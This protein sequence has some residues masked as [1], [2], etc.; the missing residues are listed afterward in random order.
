MKLSAF[1]ALAATLASPALADMTVSIP[2]AAEVGGKPFTCDGTFASLGATA[3]EVQVSDFRLFVSNPALVKA[4]GSLQPIA[5]D[6]DGAWQ[7]GDLALLDFE[8]ATGACANGT[9]GTNTTLRGTVPEGDYTGLAFTVG[10]PF[11][12]NHGD[13]TVSDAPLNV[14]AMFW[15]WQAGYKFVRIDMVPTAMAAMPMAEGEMEKAVDAGHG[16]GD[17]KGWF[18]HLGSTMCEA[19][20]KTEPPTACANGNRIEV[21]LAGFDPGANTVVIDPAPVVAG[22]DLMVNAPDTSPGCMS[23]PGDGDC[24]TVMP[25]LGL[26]FMDQPAGA[27]ALVTMR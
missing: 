4:D 15:T 2:F 1:A 7:L 24:M 10:V 14:T 18:L 20:S 12:Q 21:T 27:Q 25:L 11:A 19:A 17:A 23:A 16:H 6:Q 13:P 26:P 3:T 9:Q 8:D 5:L 22:A